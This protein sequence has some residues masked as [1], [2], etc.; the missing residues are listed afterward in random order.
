MSVGTSIQQFGHFLEECEEVVGTVHGV[1]FTGRIDA[2]TGSTAEVELTVPMAGGGKGGLAV[3]DVAVDADGRLQFVLETNTPVVPADDG[4]EVEP[5]TA[6]VTD[7]GSVT[8]SLRATVG[9]DENAD[10]ERRASVVES[11][12]GDTGCGRDVPPFRDPELLATV[13]DSCETFAEMSDAIEMDVTAETVRRY[14]IDY[15]I[16]EPER[17]DTDDIDAPSPP[18]GE[19]DRLESTPDGLSQ[20]VLTDGL[21]LPA[22]VTVDGL[23]ETVSRSNTIYEVERDVGLDRNETLDLLRRLNLLEFVVGRLSDGYDRNVGREDVIERLR[24]ASAV[25]SWPQ[26]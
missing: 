5:T 7:E 26:P 17:Y 1:E 3:D 4:L 22:E 8:A 21:G 11:D 16:H 23:V 18:S 9:G 25:Q 6:A 10:R 20:V 2:D 19:A 13:Y 12:D 24:E 14:M 15:G